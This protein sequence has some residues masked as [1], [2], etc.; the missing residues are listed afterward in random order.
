MIAL[1][2]PTE[3]TS[4]PAILL[5]LALGSLGPALAA[6]NVLLIVADDLGVDRVAAYGEHPDPGNTPVIDAL[7]ADG[8]LFRNAWTP[9]S[10]SPSRATLLTGR[11]GFRTGVGRALGGPDISGKSP[12][13]PLSETTIPELLSPGH[14][15]WAAGKWHLTSDPGQLIH[16]LEQGFASHKGSYTN[17]PGGPF[18]DTY[19][20]FKKA[21]DGVYVTS[22]TYATTDT[23][24][25]AIDF[26][27]NQGAGAPWFLWRRSTHPTHR[28]TNHRPS[29]TA[30]TCPPTSPATSRST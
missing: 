11:F 6:Q 19:S 2:R 16:P 7:A 26:I 12:G 13:L 20:N 10:C 29:C 23:V 15:S 27:Q 28:S 22:R 14:V 1:P 8:I 25:D 9:P 4:L 30:S 24:N 21:V 3:P 5:A 17:L 18:G